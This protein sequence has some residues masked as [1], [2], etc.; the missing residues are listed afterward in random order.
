M[1]QQL[2]LPHKEGQMELYLEMLV[3]KHAVK[4]SASTHSMQSRNV[5]I[6]FIFTD[7]SNSGNQT[8]AASAIHRRPNAVLPRDAGMQTF[9]EDMCRHLHSHFI[10]KKEPTKNTTEEK[11]A[12]NSISTEGH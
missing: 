1:K 6:D 7:R 5:Y 12:I 2:H 4:K 10:P 11:T 3:S 9:R 8:G